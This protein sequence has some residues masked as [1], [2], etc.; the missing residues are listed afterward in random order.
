MIWRPSLSSLFSLVSI[1]PDFLG[2]KMFPKM[3]DKFKK[4]YCQDEIIEDYSKKKNNQLQTN[5]F[6]IH[7]KK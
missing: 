2:L 3:V 1:T 7:T 5:K 6:I 4:L